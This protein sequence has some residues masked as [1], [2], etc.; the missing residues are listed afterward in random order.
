[1]IRL[2]YGRAS[3]NRN[4]F[5]VIL[6]LSHILLPVP[7]TLGGGGGG[8][9]VSV[10]RAQHGSPRLNQTQ[11]LYL[12]SL[13]LKN[14]MPNFLFWCLTWYNKQ[15]VLWEWMENCV[16]TLKVGDLK[17]YVTVLYQWQRHFKFQ[18]YWL[19]PRQWWHSTDLTEK[20]LIWKLIHLKKKIGKQSTNV[21]VCGA[22]GYWP[23]KQVDNISIEWLQKF[24]PQ[25]VQYP[26]FSGEWN[27]KSGY[28]IKQIWVNFGN[29]CIYP[30]FVLYIWHTS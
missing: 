24:V 19:I 2:D 3:F 4:S 25:N 26:H 21:T 7:S 11:G 5:S 23:C 13:S 14:W 30:F 9:G 20:L 16:N 8:G 28:K 10:S 29:K 17:L 15:I 6:G 22:R 27:I 18:W 12:E 1:M